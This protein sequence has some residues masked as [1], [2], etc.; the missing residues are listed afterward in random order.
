MKQKC[1]NPKCNYEWE[2]RVKKPKQC[3]LC[4]RYI[5]LMKFQQDLKKRK[6]KKE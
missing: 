6:E 2:A 1:L 3:P 4:K 5:P